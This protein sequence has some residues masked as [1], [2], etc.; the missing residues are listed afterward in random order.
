MKNKGFTLIEVLAVIILL[1]IIS[2]FSVTAISKIVS[3][4]KEKTYKNTI[5]ATLSAAR[6]Y[7][8][9]HLNADKVSVDELINGGYLNADDDYINRIVPTTS[10]KENKDKIIKTTCEGSVQTKIVINGVHENFKNDTST[11]NYNDC[12]C[13]KQGVSEEQKEGGLCDEVTSS[14]D[15]TPSNK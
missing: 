10:D 2:I 6:K 12:G 11:K 7:F 4:Q 13:E 5:S 15:T 8:A 14:I 9:D 3:K 1:G